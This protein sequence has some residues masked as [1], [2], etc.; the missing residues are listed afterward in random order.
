M[1][2][3]GLELVPLHSAPAAGRGHAALSQHPRVLVLEPAAPEDA[4]ARIEADP[5]D[6]ALDVGQRQLD[7]GSLGVADLYHAT[8]TGIPG[9]KV[10]CADGGYVR[11]DRRRLVTREINHGFALEESDRVGAAGPPVDEVRLELVQCLLSERDII[12]P[13]L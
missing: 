12:M 11:E 5:V 4:L 1:R 9:D 6:L 2:T 8:R 3:V 10:V 13:G 7:Q